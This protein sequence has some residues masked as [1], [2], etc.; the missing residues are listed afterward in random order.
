MDL[1]GGQVVR[2]HQGNY[3]NP[4]VYASQP[5]S[6]A[7]QLAQ[8]GIKRLHLVDLDG[9]RA[10]KP[11][12]LATL[13]SI[14]NET[15]LQIDFSGG[16]ATQTDVAAALQA[17]ASQ[18][19]IG[20][21]AA[22]HPHTVLSWI[23]HFGVKHFMLAADL[24]QGHIATRGWEESSTLTF[25]AFWSPF[26]EVGIRSCFCTIVERDGTL[27]G[28]ALDVYK[29]ILDEFPE[30]LLIASGG[31][32]SWADVEAV[33]AVGCAGVIVGKAYYEGHIPLTQLAHYAG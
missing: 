27:S 30:T 13:Q 18:V 29:A 11:Q 2:L 4:T 31:V 25:S 6:V 14:A 20:T 15:S 8:S 10:G 7:K 19:C 12:H 33:R 21:R 32:S 3:A 17:G 5:L 23:K 24:K 1:L 28:P 26:Y 16:L 9:A 22:T